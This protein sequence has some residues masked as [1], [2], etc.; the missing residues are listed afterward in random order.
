MVQAHV[1]LRGSD[2]CVQYDSTS[3]ILTLAGRLRAFG[4]RAV[5]GTAFALCT[6]PDGGPDV[7]AGRWTDVAR[8][9]PE[10][11]PRPSTVRHER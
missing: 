8:S 4:P 7:G 11:A 10:N 9:Q 1:T 3:S 5:R 2:R 6:G